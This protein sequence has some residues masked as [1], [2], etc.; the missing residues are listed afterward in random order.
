MAEY[1]LFIDGEFRDAASGETFATYNP[2]TGEKIADLPKAGRD[3]A[4]AAIEAARRAFDEGPWPRMSGAERAAKL[5]RIAELINANAEELAQL[6]AR[7][8]GGT[9]RK[10]S[11]ADVPG[12]ASAFE[13]FAKMAEE[14]P[15]RVELPGSP[16]PASQ[17]YLR[18]EPVGV[19]TGII[20]WNFP[21]I[22]A[23]WKI[24]PAL[25]AG[26]TSVLKPASFTSLTALKLAQIIA[27]ADLPAGVVNVVAGPGRHRRRGAGRQP[28]R[29]QDRL[30]RL[31]RGRPPHHAA[32]VGHGEARD[33]RA[34]WQV[35]QH[36]ARRRRPRRRRRRRAVGHLLPRRPG[37]RV[38][39]PSARAAAHLRRVRQC[40]STGPARSSSATRW[41][42]DR[43]RPARLAGPGRDRRALRGQLGRDEVGEPFCGGSHPEGLAEGL[44]RGAFYRPTIFADVDNKAKIAQEEI[45]GPVLCRHPVR[46]RRR[47]GRHRQRLDL[48]PRR[49]RAVQQPRAGRGRGRRH[50]HRHRVDQRLPPHLAGASLRW[51]QAVRHRPGAGHPGLRR[52]AR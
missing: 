52:T 17:N 50:A 15:D 7:D 38:G 20:P 47:G 35:G 21:L 27:E 49:W 45:F 41:T 31:H 46:H 11:M 33:P 22:M 18:Y 30:H 5:R 12:A 37:V 4:V 6:E 2:G 16:F 34:G 32:G 19:C 28:A 25:A 1:K 40:S 14:Q 26:N 36:R 44:D 23:A 48:R 10:A 43:P 3:D 29:R 13:W 24:A 8:G 39:H 42:S 9:I 51:L